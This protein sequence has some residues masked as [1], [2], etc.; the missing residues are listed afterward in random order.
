MP[1]SI[2]VAAWQHA[3]RQSEA[4]GIR[5]TCTRVIH[6]QHTRPQSVLCTLEWLLDRDID[7]TANKHWHSDSISTDTHAQRERERE[8]DQHTTQDTGPHC[9]KKRTE[10][11]TAK[12]SKRLLTTQHSSR[13]HDNSRAVH[14][15][16]QRARCG[17]G[18]ILMSTPCQ[19]HWDTRVVDSES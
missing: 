13:H 9:R 14:T 5:H 18:S 19:R 4:R 3:Q 17:P 6:T 11:Q 8:R 16:Q 10:P 7:H 2:L 15:Q 1:L 12:Q